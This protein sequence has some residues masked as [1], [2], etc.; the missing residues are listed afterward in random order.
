MRMRHD[1]IGAPRRPT[2]VTLS[3]E[4]VDQAKELGISV[5]RACEAGLAG[6]VKR[7]REAKWVEENMEAMLSSNRWV[8]EHGL[9]LAKFRPF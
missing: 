1:R 7:V 4:L 3:T 6:E 2:N 8:E 9:P 5:S